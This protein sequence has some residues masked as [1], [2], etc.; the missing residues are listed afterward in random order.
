MEKIKT[1]FSFLGHKDSTS[2]RPSSDHKVETERSL[3]PEEIKNSIFLPK[4]DFPMKANLPAREPELLAKWNETGLYQ[5]LREKSKERQKFVLH[6]G[7]PYANGAIHMGHALNKGLKDVIIRTYQMA[8]YNA[9]FVPGWDCHGLPIEWKVE[10]NFRKKR[11][12]KEDVTVLDFLKECR[13]FATHWVG[14]QMEGFKRL[15]I[16]A[17]WEHPYKT[18]NSESEGAIVREF[19]KIFMD[20]YIYRGKKPVLWSVVEKTALAEAEVEYKDHTSTAIF[21]AFPVA[22]TSFKELEDSAVVIWTTTPWTLPA[23]RAIAYG[24]DVRYVLLVVEEV[25]DNTEV[26]VKSG[27]K[28]V[29]AAD[30]L[31]AFCEKVGITQYRILTE[32]KGTDLKETKCQHPFDLCTQT[33]QDRM[34]LFA[35]TFAVPLLPAGH[36]TT[37]TG[38]GFVHTAPSH[39]LED[40][41][42]G[43]AF[44]LPMPDLVKGDGTYIEGLPL[45]G[46]QHIFKVTDTVLELLRQSGTLLSAE[47]LVHSYPHSWRSK[48]PLIYRLTSQWFLDIERLRGKALDAIDQVNWVPRVGRNRIR[49]MVESRPDWCLSRQRL[50]GT[51]VA[52]LVHKETQE[53]LRNSEANA[54]IVETISEEG[55]EA[56]HAHDADFF[57]PSELKGQYEKVMDTLDVWFDSASTHAFVLK[58]RADLHWPADV[59]F[60]GSDQHRGWFQSS[61]IESVATG[62]QAPYKAV[63]THGFI[64]DEDARKM[65]K[66]LGNVLSCD[67]VIQK[68]GADLLRLWLVNVDY[69]EDVK[70]SQEILKRQEDIYRR[71]RNTLRYL[72]G[73]L[74]GFSEKEF[75]SYDD[76]PELE[77]TVLHQLFVLDVKHKASMKVFNFSGFYGDLHAFCANELS[78][79][80]FDIRKDALYCDALN[81]VTRRSARTVMNILFL[82]IVHWLAPVLC[83]TAEEAWQQY[84]LRDN[85][86][87]VFDSI[88]EHL[89]PEV[90]AA[91]NR[92]DLEERW[93]KIRS[94]RRVITN[95]LEQERLAKTIT[96]S[97]QANVVLFVTKELA[98]MLKNIDMAELALVSQLTVLTAQPRAGAV[99]LEDTPDVGAI[100]TAAAGTKCPRC[101]KIIQDKEDETELCARCQNVAHL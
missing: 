64:L 11:K 21:V 59:Y 23:N 6:D 36:V 97:L 2:L 44:H 69:T 99:T 72:L 31:D 48:S 84:P 7:P 73:A 33:E 67:D 62:G 71:F 12:R 88:H 42:V 100:V 10:E 5:R 78:A 90:N 58:Q 38:T 26:G 45:L 34:S 20:G 3:S 91:W 39:G 101:W 98:D 16:C 82:H 86:T 30:L 68:Y 47:S 66:S 18:M 4:T 65:S 50:W 75:V 40:F 1:L 29:V 61:L 37:D 83:F 25:R 35:Y 49:G 51:P 41:A 54:K 85:E 53:P 27:R 56:W 63:V 22:D 70:I 19:L 17:D 52:L 76:L 46:G 32:F 79:F 93:Q 13:E 57:L 95:A 92:E 80:Y 77:K 60:E 24:E 43:Q 9:S 55:I 14:V 81:D 89:F 87:D 94:V 96:S 15:G 28:F 74:K 8:G